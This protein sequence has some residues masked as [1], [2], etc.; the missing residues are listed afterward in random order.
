MFLL[1]STSGEELASFSHSV[2]ALFASLPTCP[3]PCR[4]IIQGRRT[5]WHITLNECRKSCSGTNFGSTRVFPS[6]SSQFAVSVK[7]QG[8]ELGYNTHYALGLF[9]LASNGP[10][11]FRL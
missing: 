3:Q 1:D 4:G 9:S 2:N 10:R 7:L 11:L 8:E 6:R 5:R